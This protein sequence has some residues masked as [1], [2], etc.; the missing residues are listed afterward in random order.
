MEDI[1]LRWNGVCR[2]SVLV[3]VYLKDMDDRSFL[4]QRLKGLER[5]SRQAK[6]VQSLTQYEI[7]LVRLLAVVWSEKESVSGFKSSKSLGINRP[8]CIEDNDSEKQAV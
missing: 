3:L 6:L 8:S 2:V 4:K 7:R 5:S 1:A